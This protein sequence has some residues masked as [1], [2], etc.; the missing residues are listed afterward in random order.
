[1]RIAIACVVC[2]ACHA[3]REPQPTACD[4]AVAHVVELERA[5]DVPE[6]QIDGAP[7]A[8]GC[9]TWPRDFVACVSAATE[10]TLSSCSTTE[11]PYG[12]RLVNLEIKVARLKQR[13]WRIKA[14]IHL[15]HDTVLATSADAATPE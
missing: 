13:V 3:P 6:K 12:L 7:L 1:M 11:L 15:L 4:Q 2:A 8:A 9:A 5:A 14:R 10:E